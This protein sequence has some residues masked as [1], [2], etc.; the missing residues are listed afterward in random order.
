MKT[1]CLILTILGLLLTACSGENGA[2]QAT[3]PALQPRSTETLPANRN[4]NLG[5][6]ATR[7]TA[8]LG[9]ADP[10]LFFTDLES[11]PNTGGQDNLGAFVTIYG[12]GFGA[13]RGNSTVTIGGKAVAKYV[14]WGQDN[15]PARKMDLIVVQLGPNVT[16]GNIVVTVNGKASNSLAFTVRSGNIYF[17]ATSGSDANPGSFAQPWRTIVKAKNTIA[18]GDI[19]YVLNG[20]TEAVEE[21]FSAVL[22]IE[23]S[24]ANGLPKALVAYPGATVTI[25][26]TVLE[27]G[28]RVPNNPETMAND[29]V[30]AKLVLR[31][32]TQALD[33]GGTGSRRWRIVGNDISC[34]IGD[35]QTGCFAAALASKIAFLGNEVHGIS[36]QGSQPSKQYHAVYFTT[37]TNHVE[38]GWNHIHDNNTCRAVQ[39]HS[40]PLNDTTGYNQYDL[41]VHDNLIHGDVCDGINFA[42][43]DPSKGPARAFNNII[44]DVGRGPAPPDGDANYTC[45]YVAGSTNTGADGKGNVEIFN[46]T[47]F[48]CGARRK[49]PNPTNDEGA[50][51]RGPGSPGLIMN[52]RSNII[53]LV[54]GEHYI[55]PSSA[56]APIQGSHNLWFGAGAPPAF[57]TGNVTAG[58]QFIDIAARD[59]RPKSGSPAIDA[60]VSANVGSDYLGVLRPQGRAYDIGAYEVIA[61]QKVSE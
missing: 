13:S 35:G 28:V 61:E 22:S 41:N 6:S 57:L 17:V 45:I 42:T 9:S 20:V 25:G 43:V 26:S 1:F 3:P 10:R 39:F 49:L 23:T 53:Y 14:V 37:D 55:S 59:F 44:Y 29:W 33:I 48:D 50:F 38:V 32:Q 4:P 40:S 27:F 34:P 19:A 5:L 7:P 36:T 11:G 21:N 2:I 52:L 56:T 47:L 30:I 46:N 54:A 16:S 12:E 60:G 51:G 31:G 8:P 24:G 18:P 58:P 15:A